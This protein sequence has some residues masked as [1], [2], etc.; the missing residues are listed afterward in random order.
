M[1]TYVIFT[2]RDISLNPC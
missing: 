1:K 2:D